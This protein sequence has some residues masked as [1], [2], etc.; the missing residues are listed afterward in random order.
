M[1]K[2][3]RHQEHYALELLSSALLETNTPPSFSFRVL[4]FNNAFV[5]AAVASYMLH[6]DNYTFK[7]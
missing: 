5:S 3:T 6:P 1:S 2:P 7:A 4:N